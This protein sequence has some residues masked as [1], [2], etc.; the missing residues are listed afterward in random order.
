[1]RA[2][3]SWWMALW[4]TRDV[5]R[6]MALSPDSWGCCWT[7]LQS[8][9]TMQNLFS[10][11]SYFINCKVPFRSL[12]WHNC[13]TK[14]K[15][16]KLLIYD[17]SLRKKLDIAVYWSVDYVP[18]IYL[19][20]EYQACTLSVALILFLSMRFLFFIYFNLFLQFC[21]VKTCQV[22]GLAAFI[23]NC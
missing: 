3:A 18:R 16:N 15:S 23:S 19:T 2:G 14:R 11:V 20:L 9:A 17:I 8:R 6:A 21:Y 5:P 4:W 7:L 13:E 22:W 10:R 1:M 12:Y